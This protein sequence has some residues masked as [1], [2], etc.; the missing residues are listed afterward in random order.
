MRKESFKALP[1]QFDSE[2]TLL[3]YISTVGFMVGL[4][5]TLRGP[6]YFHSTYPEGWQAEYEKNN[7]MFI[8][9]M[10]FWGMTKTG[11]C[12]WSAV[13]LTRATPVFKRAKT[14]GLEYGATI[15]TTAG[16]RRSL[17]SVARSDRELEDDE[18]ARCSE[19]IGKLAVATFNSNLTIEEIDTLKLVAEGYAQKEIAAKLNLAEPTIKARL[20]KVKDKLGARNTT[21]A[22]TM[23]IA[24]K[25]I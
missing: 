17:L 18:L 25:L 21:H 11:A 10:L 22:V 13:A 6:E 8:D 1:S 5:V 9:P 3:S 23:A 4:N 7:Y 24:A 14:H 15:S 19:I 2:L 20:S 16:G 12:R